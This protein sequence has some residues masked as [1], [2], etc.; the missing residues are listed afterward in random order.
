MGDYIQEKIRAIDRSFER[1]DSILLDGKKQS[2]LDQMHN[3]RDSIRYLWGIV[4]GCILAGAI[5]FTSLILH[6]SNDAS[7]FDSVIAKMELVQKKSC[8]TMP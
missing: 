8:T 6:I 2:L 5:V 7:K 1:I 4:L 3:N